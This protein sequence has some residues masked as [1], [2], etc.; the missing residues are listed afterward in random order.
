MIF[1]LGAW[2][3][4]CSLI[5]SLVLEARISIPVVSQKPQGQQVAPVPRARALPVSCSAPAQDG[6]R[7]LA[8][9][10]RLL[11]CLVRLVRRL[12]L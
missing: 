4:V 1:F 8:G 11:W 10:P 12:G 6:S 7:A 9:A 3:P 2:S 5:L